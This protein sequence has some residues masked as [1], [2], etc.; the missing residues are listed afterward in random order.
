MRVKLLPSNCAD[1]DKLQPLTTLLVNDR[2]PI[3]AGSIGFALPLEQQRHIRHII[4]THAH[5]DHTASL[6]IFVA[7]VFPF[8]EM[9]VVVHGLKHTIDSLRTHI[10]ND[11]IWPDFEKISIS[12]GAGPALVFDEIVPGVPFEVE[13]LR[14]TPVLTNHIVPSVGVAVEDDRVTV[15][16]TSDTYHT[17]EVWQL[18]NRSEKL[19]AIF[20]D[21]SYPNELETLAAASKHLTPQALDQELTKLTRNVPIYAVHLKPQF[22]TQVVDEL[23][24]LNRDNVFVAE[25]GWEYAW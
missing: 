24:R 25:I 11:S 19:R 18:A 8:L 6:P 12:N 15:I 22:R 20:V 1:P 16:F 9:P 21:V 7:E 3:D 17:D 10:F 14:I 13:G 23:S 2:L 5:S 4:I